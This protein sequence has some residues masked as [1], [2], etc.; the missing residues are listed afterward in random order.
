MISLKNEVNKTCVNEYKDVPNKQR[1]MTA[2]IYFFRF[3]PCFKLQIKNSKF[4]KLLGT[5]FS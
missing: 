4:C 5:F 3:G 2:L 1:C